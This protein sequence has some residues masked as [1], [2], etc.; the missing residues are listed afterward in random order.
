MQPAALEPPAARNRYHGAGRG[1]LA[2]G[3]F[4][5][6]YE[7]ILAVRRAARREIA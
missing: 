1:T 7:E 6:D 4:V 2:G 3:F 5:E